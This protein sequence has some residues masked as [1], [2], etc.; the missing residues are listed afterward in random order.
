MQILNFSF[1]LLSDLF[2]EIGERYSPPLPHAAGEIMRK[3]GFLQTKAYQSK[4]KI[5]FSN[6]L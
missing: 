4:I 6:F 1:A 5:N 2:N 3:T